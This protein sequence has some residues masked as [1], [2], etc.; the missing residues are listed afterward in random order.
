MQIKKQTCKKRLAIL[1]IC[2]AGVSFFILFVQSIMDHYGDDVPDAWAWLLPTIMPT[3][4][5]II[6]VLVADAMGRSMQMETVDI[7]IYRLAFYLSLTYLL[8]VAMQLFAQPF[9]PIPPLELMRKSNLW[10]GPYQGLVSAC[11]GAFFI[12]SG[13]K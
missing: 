9:S 2:G 10:L 8:V 7:F 5:L 1:W 6:G 3:L 11:L 12:S 13:K 4:S